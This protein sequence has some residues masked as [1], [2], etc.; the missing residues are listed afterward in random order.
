MYGV[1]YN[2]FMTCNTIISTFQPLF[3]TPQGETADSP[4]VLL[5]EQS[6]TEKLAFPF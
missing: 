4:A 2:T 1:W 6:T 5:E 3:N